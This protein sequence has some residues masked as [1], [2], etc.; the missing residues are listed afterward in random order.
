MR[1]LI[2]LD[3]FCFSLL[4]ALLA[5]TVS[6]S[7][8]AEESSFKVDDFSERY[9]AI[10]TI[11]QADKKDPHDLIATISVFDKQREVEI[12]RSSSRWDNKEIGHQLPKIKHV[13]FPVPQARHETL[14][15]KDQPWFLYEDINFD[16]RKDFALRH[17]WQT[18][19]IYQ[20]SQGYELYLADEKGNF[21]LDQNNTIAMQSLYPVVLSVDKKRQ[22]L[23]YNLPSYQNLASYHAEYQLIDKEVVLVK[24]T[25]HFKH[26]PYVQYTLPTSEFNHGRRKLR[27]ERYVDEKQ[28]LAE[29]VRF[30]RANQQGVA[31]VF[32][33]PQG[34]RVVL[35]QPDGVI[36]AAYESFLYSEFEQSKIWHFD[37]EKKTL[38]QQADGS[39]IFY[40]SNDEQLKASS[41]LSKEKQESYFSQVENTSIYYHITLANSPYHGVVRANGDHN[42]KGAVW[43]SIQL[44][45]PGV[46]ERVRDWLYIDFSQDKLRSNN[47][48][49]SEQQTLLYLADINFDGQD[50]VIYRRYLPGKHKT[51]LQVQPNYKVAL[52]QD[53]EFIESKSYS[54]IL[55]QRSWVLD[56]TD[57][58][59]RI[60]TTRRYED[61]DGWE[62]SKEIYT[63]VDG[64]PILMWQ[65]S[66]LYKTGIPYSAHRKS[67]RAEPTSRLSVITD[68]YLVDDI[69][70]LL[71]RR[72]PEIGVNVKYTVYEYNNRLYITQIGPEGQLYYT[73]HGEKSDDQ[74]YYYSRKEKDEDF[75]LE[76][77]PN[78]QSLVYGGDDN[79]EL[80]LQGRQLAIALQANNARFNW[81]HQLTDEEL[82]NFQ[83]LLKQPLE[84]MVVNMLPMDIPDT[85]YYALIKRGDRTSPEPDEQGRTL[86]IDR[87]KGKIV[88][89]MITGDSVVRDELFDGTRQAIAF[90]EQDIVHHVDV[91]FDGKKDLVILDTDAWVGSIYQ[92][93]LADEQGFTYSEEFT[94]LSADYCGLFTVDEQEKT[95]STN[96]CRRA[97]RYVFTV[98]DNLPYLIEHA[99]SDYYHGESFY[100]DLVEG[101]PINIY[102]R[103][104]GEMQHIPTRDFKVSFLQ[105]DNGDFTSQLILYYQFEDGNQMYFFQRTPGKIDFMLAYTTA[106]NKLI[107]MSSSYTINSSDDPPFFYFDEG[108]LGYEFKMYEG[109][110][111]V[112]EGEKTTKKVPVKDIGL[113][114]W[115]WLRFP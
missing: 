104:D 41:K 52:Q 34:L 7:A 11:K 47:Y 94:D 30:E 86:L 38:L 14:S 29:L 16:G 96:H 99:Y 88:F 58:M 91:N 62:D 100:D 1:I 67:Y 42:S 28:H 21:T 92:V 51:A 24:A 35:E 73:H 97:E 70:I 53:G 20:A 17:T 5:V 68:Y 115:H 64:Q 56:N 18:F 15:Y 110:L 50:D 49:F 59:Q 87:E 36:D 12:L 40:L 85:P 6:A 57:N 69:T 37:E 95:L 26:Q 113:D 4:F 44:I 54:A 32:F 22:R 103:I 9:E 112:I 66:K 48:E 8:K 45:E 72:I 61:E 27:L 80:K 43:A 23:I 75:F 114:Q 82:Q 102:R 105:D 31:R 25:T 78:N 60:E 77:R 83:R 74:L 79:N 106:D 2:F 108:F 89:E 39:F 65:E 3:K 33:S 84:N 19:S 111:E 13:S 81:R 63:V 90:D 93:Y 109:W 46:G 55:E 98:K 101:D 107:S 76:Y 10:I 71:Q